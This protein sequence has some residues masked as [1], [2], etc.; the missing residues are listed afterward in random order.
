MSQDINSHYFLSNLFFSHQNIFTAF[1]NS[2]DLSALQCIGAGRR[3][4]ML[5]SLGN[6]KIRAV[7]N[8]VSQNQNHIKYLKI[9][10][11][12]I[13]YTVVK[14]VINEKKSNHVI[15]F[16]HSIENCFSLTEPWVKTNSNQK[17]TLRQ[18]NDFISGV[19]FKNTEITFPWDCSLENSKYF[20]LKSLCTWYFMS[21]FLKSLVLIQN[22]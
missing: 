9:R 10:L 16:Q 19:Y 13:S 7:F 12:R 18:Q 4:S 6:C 14:Q 17:W 1:N 2:H 11:L 5:I 8:W 15:T 22:N 3:N 20:Y 21:V